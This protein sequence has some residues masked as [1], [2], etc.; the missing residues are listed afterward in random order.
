MRERLKKS[1]GGWGGGP[2][3][4]R[5]LGRYM[6]Y[7]RIILKLIFKKEDGGVK[8][9]GVAQVRDRWRLLVNA[10]MNLRFP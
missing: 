1:D 3:G 10:E 6:F 7:G 9:N 5:T 8:W 2:E 4:T